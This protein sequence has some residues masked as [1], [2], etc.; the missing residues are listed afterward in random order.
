MP[1]SKPL[2]QGKIYIKK[3]SKHGYGVFAGQNFKKGDLIEECYFI[4]SRGGDKGLE[5]YYFDIKGKYGLF[6]GYGCI[7][8]H[9]EDPNADY[10]INRK[11]K[12]A[13]IKAYRRIKKGDE[14]F[15]SYGDDWFKTRNKR[16]K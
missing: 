7:Y 14:I 9:D 5:D 15:I 16:P 4:V 1:R 8:N 12:I 10:F 6:F 11:S 2:H 3:S 13:K